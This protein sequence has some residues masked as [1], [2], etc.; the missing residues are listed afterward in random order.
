MTNR[1]G[2]V[3]ALV[4]AFSLFSYQRS[5]SQQAGAPGSTSR[6]AGAPGSNSRPAGAP[7]SSSRPAGLPGSD[8]RPAGAPGSNTQQ[9]GASGLDDQSKAGRNMFMNGKRKGELSSSQTQSLTKRLQ[10]LEIQSIKT[11]KKLRE[12]RTKLKQGNPEIEQLETELRLTV[13]FAF[14]ARQKLQRSDVVKLRQRLLRVE[15]QLDSREGL[16]SKIIDRRIQELADPN[17]NWSV[18][19]DGTSNQ[20]RFSNDF[21]SGK[22]GT[23]FSNWP[24][25]F[26]LKKEALLNSADP[27]AVNAGDNP[28]ALGRQTDSQPNSVLQQTSPKAVTTTAIDDPRPKTRL[29][30][31]I[32]RTRKARHDVQPKRDSNKAVA[33]MEVIIQETDKQG[34]DIASAAYLHGTV[35][36]PDGL[37][38]V[39]VG[40]GNPADSFDTRKITATATFPGNKPVRAKFVRYD[41]KF[42]M[43]LFQLESYAKDFLKPI[44]GPV[45]IGRRLT[46][47][48]LY[49]E[50]QQPVHWAT[51]VDTVTH[52]HGDVK[53]LV[54]VSSR[55]SS[56]NSSSSIGGALVAQSGELNGII[57]TLSAYVPTA[58]NETEGYG[59]RRPQKLVAIPS[60]AIL[61]LLKEHQSKN[62]SVGNK[63]AEIKR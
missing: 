42:G 5:N 19:A 28:G 29:D 24:V 43:A 3:L 62:G 30:S 44:D 7:G 34:N 10:L 35:V 47:V 57:S 55:D 49:G 23:E 39:C 13:K 12:A 6:P 16:K 14:E 15:R 27:N 11:G 38:V 56:Q 21:G 31:E 60:S 2:F 9:A 46:M 54:L 58:P 26:K 48:S 59:S 37:I 61:Q 53:D 33:Y 52:T 45:P 51:G 36:S 8:S 32:G 40:P 25:P 17:L 18:P 50:N 4:V 63:P 20:Q 41:P 22:F 1:L